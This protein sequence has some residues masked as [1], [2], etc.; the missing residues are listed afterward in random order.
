MMIRRLSIAFSLAFLLAGAGCKGTEQVMGTP[1]TGQGERTL[2]SMQPFITKSL[3][4]PVAELT[5]GR[6]DGGEGGAQ[7]LFIYNIEEGRKVN[8]RFPNQTDPISS[9]WVQEKNGGVT[10]LQIL[11]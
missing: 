6:P 3:T 1:K 2:A 9:A 7:V 10:P 8:L 11:P 5:F 4:A